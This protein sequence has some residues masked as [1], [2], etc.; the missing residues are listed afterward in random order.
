MSYLSWYVPFRL[1]TDFDFDL[2]FLINDR[3]KQDTTKVR[4][5]E[6]WCRV[7]DFPSEKISFCP[8]ATFLPHMQTMASE[9][10]DYEN[11]MKKKAKAKKRGDDFIDYSDAEDMKDH[12]YRTTKRKQQG[13][14]LFSFVFYLD[15][16][17][18]SCLQAGLLFQTEV[19]VI[20][21]FQSLWRS[22]YFLY[23]VLSSHCRWGP[24]HS[25]PTYKWVTFSNYLVLC[26]S[27]CML[28]MSRAITDL[29]ATYRWC[30][31]GTPIVNSLAD[32]YGLIRFLK[33]RPWYDWAH[34][35]S[36]IGILEKKKR[37]SSFEFFS[38]MWW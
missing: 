31:T 22:W 33:I 34:F 10:P 14:P 6:A 5:L 9:W 29:N 35:Q 24:K 25:K 3:P 2:K 28:G 27:H 30:L 26:C 32:V 19:G 18:L 20:F 38:S 8:I 13:N 15:V 36:K 11:E 1:A 17:S 21:V 7:D 16:N 12:G 4:T 37:E 23:L